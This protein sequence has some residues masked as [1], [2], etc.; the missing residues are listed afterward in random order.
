MSERVVYRM[1][2]LDLIFSIFLRFH[3]NS[4]RSLTSLS[5]QGWIKSTC[6]PNFH[7]RW[8]TF[9]SNR[10]GN[11]LS[12][13][14]GKSRSWLVCSKFH[15]INLL[16]V[17]LFCRFLGSKLFEDVS[18]LVTLVC[19]WYGTQISTNKINITRY[20]NFVLLYIEDLVL[21]PLWISDEHTWPPLFFELTFPLMYMKHTFTYDP[22]VASIQA[23]YCMVF[24]F[25]LSEVKVCL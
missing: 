14:Y 6:W 24:Y 15:Q 11:M 18:K 16:K 21:L 17:N 25:I 1:W 5:F 7:F 12:V 3:S 8:A 23:K 22:T 10:S 13:F 20:K 4:F 2:Q 19:S 9:W